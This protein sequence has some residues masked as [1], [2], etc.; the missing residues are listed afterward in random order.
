MFGAGNS[1][2][3]HITPSY[4]SILEIVTLRSLRTRIY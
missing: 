4:V 2:V 3:A 1:M